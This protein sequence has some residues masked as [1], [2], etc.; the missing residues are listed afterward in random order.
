MEPSIKYLQTANS[1]SWSDLYEH[2][3]SDL[4]VGRLVEHHPLTL[5]VHN[6]KSIITFCILVLIFT[7]CRHVEP[8]RRS[9][10]AEILHHIVGEWTSSESSD[11]WHRVMII[12]ED[13]SLISV[14]RDG[15]R[16]LMGRWELSGSVLRV[17]PTTSRLEAARAAGLP[18]NAWD[19]YPVVYA[20]DHE[21]VMAPGI[22]VGGR[23]RYRR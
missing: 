16:E 22:S 9:T 19:Y 1:W 17:T 11:G 20:D 3:D 4:F 10:E 21:L 13:G 23:L 2:Q 15:T 12:S 8:E 5:I 6:V 14:Q 18:M 7:A